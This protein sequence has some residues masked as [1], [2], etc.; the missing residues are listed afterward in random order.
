MTITCTSFEF[1]LSIFGPSQT[2]ENI[3]R[4]TIKSVLKHTNTKVF[5][6][7][8]LTENMFLV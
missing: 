6:E 7:N 4:G 2:S 8:V 3:F 5:P 1:I